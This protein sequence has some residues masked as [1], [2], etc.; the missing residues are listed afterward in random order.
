MVSFLSPCVFPLAPAYL[1]YLGG[2]AGEAA[3]AQAVSAGRG[4]AGVAVAVRGGGAVATRVPVLA[5]GA[6]F[7]LGF[8][9][10]FIGFYY[11][12]R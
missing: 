5:N 7:V 11:V 3:Q 12:L 6:A 4:G 2:R 1:A 9:A 10:V 8:S